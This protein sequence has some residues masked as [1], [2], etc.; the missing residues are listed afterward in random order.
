MG[1]TEVGRI[2]MLADLDYFYAQVEERRDRSLI[3]RPVVVCVY[4]G[5]TEESG[6]VATANYSARGYGV[7]SGIPIALAKKRLLGTEA[8]FLPMDHEFYKQVSERVMAIL[9]R[10]VDG[11]EQVGIDEAYLDVSNRVANFQEAEKLARKIKDEVWGS[12]SLTLSIGVG[13]NKVIAK[14]AADINKPNGLTVVDEEDSKAFLSPLPVESLVGVGRKT[15]ERMGQLGIRTVGELAAFDETTLINEFGRALGAYFHRAAN[16]EDEEAVQERGENE[17]ISRMV[18]LKEDTNDPKKVLEAAYMLCEDVVSKARERG[19]L[20]R[21]VGIIAVTTDLTI[22]MREKSLTAPTDDMQTVKRAVKEILE[23]HL[24]GNRQE[25]RRV[26]VHISGFVRR[27]K[28][29][30]QLT[31]FI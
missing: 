10:N 28:G 1:A 31:T 12:E 3:G 22:R 4:S 20:F 2:V 11:F 18:T 8:R 9:K 7:R 15:A 21:R 23:K 30:S 5:R 26:G 13:P 17:S 27:M 24:G 14:I 16:G 19:L 25:L 6:V 29:Q